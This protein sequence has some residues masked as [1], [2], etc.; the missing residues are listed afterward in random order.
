MELTVKELL[1]VLKMRAT[2]LQKD[3]YTLY[4]DDI[5]PRIEAIQKVLDEIKEKVL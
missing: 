3:M 5:P 2:S 1:E 4:N